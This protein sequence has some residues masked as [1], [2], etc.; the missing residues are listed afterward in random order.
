[1]N[2][3]LLCLEIFFA[4]LIDVSIGS[5]RTIYLVKQKNLIACC[6]A[7]IEVM[8]WF[9]IARQALTN[10]NASFLVVISYAGGYA[11]GT[12]IGGLINKYLVKGTLTAMIITDNNK[13]NLI[14]AI[15]DS[16]YGVSIIKLEDDKMMLLVETKKKNLKRLKNLII[17][18]DRNAFIIVSETLQVENG[19]IN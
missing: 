11:V 1:M 7:F 4:R 5:V 8:I 6:L 10:E 18:L 2:T 15:K 13:K 14:E 12:Y 17:S 9:Y 3:L 16:K 19:Y